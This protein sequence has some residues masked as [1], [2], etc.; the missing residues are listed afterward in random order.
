[1]NDNDTLAVVRDSLITAKD[2]LAGIHMDT[3][4]DAIARTGRARR[5]SHRLTGLTGALA[6]VAG[7]ALAVAAL[8]HPAT[9]P[10]NPATRRAS[11]AP[12]SW[13]PGRWPSRPMATSRSP[14][15]S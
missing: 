3:P 7:T 2:S 5:R 6:L 11:R 13:R 4:P 1:M 9:R 10:A 8:T 12:P 15:A 14:S